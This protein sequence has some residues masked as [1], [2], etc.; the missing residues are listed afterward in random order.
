MEKNAKE[1]DGRNLASLDYEGWMRIF[2]LLE[3][4]EK[5]CMRSMD[6]IEAD[7]QLRND[8]RFRIGNMLYGIRVKA[9]YQMQP[10]F[11]RL[12]FVAPYAEGTE[13]GW[14]FT[15]ETCVSY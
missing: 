12:P 1:P 14:C 5:R 7:M 8:N 11:A 15:E 6:I 2:L 13:E 10:R 9:Q 3:D 4:R